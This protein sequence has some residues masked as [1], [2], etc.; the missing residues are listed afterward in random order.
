MEKALT[1]RWGELGPASATNLFLAAVA[2]PNSV[3]WFKERAEALEVYWESSYSVA[4][5]EDA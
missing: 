3:R 1:N 5:H 4:L 2:L